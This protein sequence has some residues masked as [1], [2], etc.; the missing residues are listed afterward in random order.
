M[1]VSHSRTLGFSLSA[2]ALAANENLSFTSI[3]CTRRS[4]ADHLL[5]SASGKI[6]GL[7]RRSCLSLRQ[8]PVEMHIAAVDEQMLASGVR[9]LWGDQEQNC[10]GD[11]FGLRHTL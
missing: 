9:C 10:C 4:A 7:A 8:C 1:R 5:G 6:S 2:F 11:L 3:A